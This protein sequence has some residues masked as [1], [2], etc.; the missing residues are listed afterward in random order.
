MKK[1]YITAMVLVLVAVF[2][3][4]ASAEDIYKEQYDASGADTLFDLL[5]EKNRELLQSFGEGSEG[6]EW[7]K[8]V[9]AENIFLQIFEFINGEWKAPMRA[10]AV[11]TAVLLIAA[12]VRS[13]APDELDTTLSFICLAGICSAVI[14]PACSLI[15]SLSSALSSASVFMSGFVPILVISFSHLLNLVS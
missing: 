4:C 8:T 6:E 2:S 1:L 12:A 13:V 7:I 9:R 15:S 11:C 3:V 5:P 10:V 14:V